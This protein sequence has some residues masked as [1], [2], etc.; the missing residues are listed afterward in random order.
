MK[1]ISRVAIFAIVLVGLSAC[2]SSQDPK[3]TTSPSPEIAYEM[4]RDGVGRIEILSKERAK[5]TPEAREAKVEG[6]VVLRVI[7]RSD[8]TITQLKVVK[9]LP[10]GLTEKAI[11]AANKIKFKPAE[12]DGKPVS[13]N[14]HIEYT[15]SLY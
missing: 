5:Y 15:F 8:G 4:G 12:K 3:A 10:Y 2:K 1:I 14:G 7:F 13:V 9:E 6:V 11:E